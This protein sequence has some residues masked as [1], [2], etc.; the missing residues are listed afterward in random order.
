MPTSN[1]QRARWH[2]GLLLIM[3]NILLFAAGPWLRSHT[4]SSNTADPF[5]R[6]VDGEPQIDTRPLLRNSAYL[7]WYLNEVRREHKVFMLG[8]S[9]STEPFNLAAQLNQIAPHHPPIALAASGGTSPIHLSV[10]FSQCHNTDTQLPPVIL[11]LNL[12]YYMRSHDLVNESWL[13]NVVSTPVF[14]FMNHENMRT[15]LTA[16]ANAVYD[17]HFQHWHALYPVWTQQYLSHLL[18]LKFHQEPKGAPRPPGVPIPTYTFDGKRPMYDE[19]RAVAPG[20][21]A[22]DQLA[23]DRWLVHSADEAVNLKGLA[24]TMAILD[25][26]PAPVLLVILPMNRKYYGYYGMDMDDFEARY[27][28]IRKQIRNF[29]REK[30]IWVIDLYEQPSLDGG[31]MDRMHQDAYGFYQLAQYLVAHSDEYAAFMGEVARHYST[32]LVEMS[33][34]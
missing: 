28:G 5:F 12:V 11:I 29:E 16:E 6:L 9:E 10:M 17:Q 24:A 22:S 34:Q 3:A 15:G 13:S 25:E 14:L 4:F 23:R 26:Q 7:K 27:A 18:Y 33:H 31:F 21:K 2:I 20:Y 19:H 1:D 30:H 32:T 8:T